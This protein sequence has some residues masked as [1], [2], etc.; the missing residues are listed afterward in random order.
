ML[1]PPADVGRDALLLELD[2]QQRH[3][4]V[5]VSLALSPRLLD[6]VRELSVLLGVQVLEAQVLELNLDPVDAEPI[7]ERREDVERLLRDALLLLLLEEAQRPHIV[8]AVSELD[9]DDAQIAA[10]RDQHLAEVLGRSLLGAREVQLLKLSHAV[11][12]KRDVRPELRLDLIDRGDCVLD[13]VVQQRGAHARGVQPEVRH[14]VADL[15]GVHQIGLPISARL[16]SVGGG[17]VD[18][19]APHEVDVRGGMMLQEKLDHVVEANH[20]GDC[21]RAARP[22]LRGAAGPATGRVRC[23]H[24][25]LRRTQS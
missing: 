17:A 13:R 2:L 5:D 22:A 19:G 15:E 18:I 6:E 12:E 4:A 25:S 24:T 11:D 9:Q 16:P 3:H 1:R 21:I 8:Q 14:D 7:R 10:H 23:A 20:P